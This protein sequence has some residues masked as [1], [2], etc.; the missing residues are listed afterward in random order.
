MENKINDCCKAS[1]TR[2]ADA[3]FKEGREA[4]RREMMEM[5]KT[6]ILLLTN[7]G[8]RTKKEMG[9]RYAEISHVQVMELRV[10][11]SDLSVLLDKRQSQ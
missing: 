9:D 1:N 10:I 6:R 11:V 8:G 3:A 4:A 2:V 7:G 5:V